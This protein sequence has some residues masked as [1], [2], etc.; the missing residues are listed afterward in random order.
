MPACDSVPAERCRKLSHPALSLLGSAPCLLLQS[1]A[2][3]VVPS[4]VPV[5][6]AATSAGSR[7]RLFAT[8]AAVVT[9]LLAL[10]NA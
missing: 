2:A 7:S 8:G 6:P 1:P 10:I 5:S 4:P 9:A 3:E